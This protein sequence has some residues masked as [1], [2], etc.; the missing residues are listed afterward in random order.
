[1]KRLCLFT[2]SLE[3]SGVGAHVLTLAARLRQRYRVVVSCP[4]SE[5]GCALLA[6]VRALGIDTLELAERADRPALEQAFSRCIRTVDIFHVHAG[7]GW[8][9]IPAVW[10]ARDAG[11][12]VVLRTE[13]LPY[14]LT[15]PDQQTAF[16]QM[17]HIVDRIVCVSDG[18]S[19]S[20]RAAGTPP[21][22]LAVVRNGIDPLPKPLNRDLARQDLRLPDEA[23]LILTV[24][25]FTEQKGYRFLAEAAAPVVQQCPEVRLLWVGDGPEREPLRRQVDRLGLSEHVHFLGRRDDVPRLLGAADLF[26]LPSLFEGLPLVVLEAMAAGLPVIGTRVCGTEEAIR[27]GVTG[28]LVPPADSRALACALLDALTRPGVAAGWGAAARRAREREFGA[29]RMVAE[30]DAI[31]QEYLNGGSSAWSRPGTTVESSHPWPRP[32]DAASAGPGDC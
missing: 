5:G 24:G 12:P 9:G 17:T 15:D 32:A 22:K 28:R 11:I 14:L 16:E 4:R 26:V 20:L 18:V 1:M 29:A 31:Y 6:R 27:D 30:L 25:R 2:D 8:E 3:P 21:G 19:A 10:F 13:H 23:R 7:I